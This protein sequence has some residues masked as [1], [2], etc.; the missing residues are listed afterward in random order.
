MATIVSF[1]GVTEQSGMSGMPQFGENIPNLAQ[2]YGGSVRSVKTYISG[3]VSH[4]DVVFDSVNLETLTPIGMSTPA[5]NFGEACAA[6]GQ[7][8]G[9]GQTRGQ[10]LSQVTLS[11]PKW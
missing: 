10:N 7:A 2:S 8:Y 1:D 4:V 5:K 3:G 9:A 6:M 11:I